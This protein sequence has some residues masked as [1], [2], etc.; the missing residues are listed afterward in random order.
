MKN[1]IGIAKQ[2]IVNGEYYV[3]IN[4]QT[5]EIK[6]DKIK[7]R[8]WGKKKLRDKLFIGSK[9]HEHQE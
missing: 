5:G 7:F 8:P 6:S 9:L 3:S 1:I 2:S 4:F